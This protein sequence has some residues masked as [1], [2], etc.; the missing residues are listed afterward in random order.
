[1]KKLGDNLLLLFL[2]AVVVVG[3]YAYLRYAYRVTDSTPFTQEIVLIILGTVATI[4]ITAALLNKQSAVE[5]DKEQS[6][7][8]I[9]LKTRTYEELINQ[10]EQIVLSKEVTDRDLVRLQFTTHRLAIFAAPAVLEEYQEFLRVFNRAAVDGAVSAIESDQLTDSLA[11]LTVEIRADLIGELDRE[12]D[13]GLQ[14]IAEQIV[15][16]ASET[17]GRG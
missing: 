15:E 16:N 7:K 11:R 12:S 13:I 4:L 14:K 8:F 6:V 10:I 17:T 2:T 9:D 1:M 5:I 3:G